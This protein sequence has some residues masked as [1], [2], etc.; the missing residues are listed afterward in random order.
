MVQLWKQ[1]EAIAKESK[2]ENEK[3]RVLGNPSKHDF[4]V[5]VKLRSDSGL[6]SGL[7]CQWYMKN[8]LKWVTA[9]TVRICDV[10][11]CV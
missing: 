2:G 1:K 7:L 6:W 8:V 11:V 4:T 9:E 5:N 3:E 10:S